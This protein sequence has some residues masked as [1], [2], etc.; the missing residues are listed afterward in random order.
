MAEEAPKRSV[1]LAYPYTPEGLKT[2]KAPGSTISVPEQVAIDLVD[3]G[4]AVYAKSENV[5]EPEDIVEATTAASAAAGKEK[6]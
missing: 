1:V 2:P 4:R 6:K 3:S 5:P